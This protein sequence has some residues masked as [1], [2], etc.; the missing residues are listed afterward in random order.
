MTNDLAAAY[1]NRGVALDN[2][3][4]FQDAINDYER[5]IGLMDKLVF[6]DNFSP[7]IPNLPHVFYMALLAFHKTDDTE[8]A[9]KMALRATTFLEKIPQLIDIH[10]LPESWQKKFIDLEQILTHFP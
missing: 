8:G 4:L 9:R 10:S 6:R 5:A 7:A 2:K 3:N 1:M